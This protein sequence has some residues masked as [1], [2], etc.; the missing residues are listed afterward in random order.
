MSWATYIVECSDGSLYTGISNNVAKRIKTHNAGKGAHYT[1]GRAPVVL[2][3]QIECADRS[4]ASK[5]EYQIK[6]LSR[7]EKLKLINERQNATT[8]KS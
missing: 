4:S 1:R 5:L 6:K 2:L 3:L 8:S 7:T